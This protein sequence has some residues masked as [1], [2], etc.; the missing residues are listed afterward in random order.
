MTYDP[1]S[2]PTTEPRQE[3]AAPDPPFQSPVRRERSLLQRIGGGIVALGL[4]AVKFG[5]LL[6]GVLLKFKFAFSFLLAIGAYALLWGWEFGVGFVVLL[7]IHEMGHVIQLR[8]E[9][10]P[11]SAPMFIPFLGAFV[12]MKG[13]PKDAY[14]EAKVGLAGPVLGS[15]AAFGTLALAEQTNSNLLRALAYTGFFLN[16]F[17]LIP[18]VPL[19][20]GRAFAALH[21]AT[22]F[23][24]LFI[25]ALLAFHYQNP[26]IFIVLIF[27]SFELYQRWQHRND[28]GMA[29]YHAITMTQ[30]VWVFAVYMGLVVALVWG[31]HAAH[32]TVR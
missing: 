10:V 13:M 30:R 29:A 3:P 1:W 23:L 15:V 4:A 7:A 26:F 9:G 22:W 24:G 12:Q 14:V 19:D 32:V 27:V 2:T 5:G 20:G 28:P 17:N 8:R 16:L 11:A 25:V 6:F 31:M 21:P 18:V